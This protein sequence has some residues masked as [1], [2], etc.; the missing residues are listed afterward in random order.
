MGFFK[1]FLA[2]AGA[3]LITGGVA[4]GVCY[5][6]VPEFKDWVQQ[7]LLKIETPVGAVT[8]EKDIQIAD[9]TAQLEQ[10][11][12]TIQAITDE[13]DTQRNKVSQLQAAA[14]QD[15]ETIATLQTSI[16]EK[17]ALLDSATAEKSQLEEQKATL[18]ADLAETQAELEEAQA[19]AETDA[20]TIASLQADV[21]SKQ[22]ELADVNSQLETKTTEV[23][24]LTT[25]VQTLTEERDQ[26]LADLETKES[27]ITTLNEEIASLE[28]DVATKESEIATLNAR[29]ATLEDGLIKDE[30]EMFLADYLSKGF[31]FFDVSEDYAFASNVGF[32]NVKRN[33]YLLNKYDYSLDL[34]CEGYQ[35]YHT[36]FKTDDNRYV[37]SAGNNGVCVVESDLST[38]KTYSLGNKSEQYICKYTMPNGSLVFTNK[39]GTNTSIDFLFEDTSIVVSSENNAFNISCT[40]A[41]QYNKFFVGDNTDSGSLYVVDST[42]GECSEIY[43]GASNFYNFEER[44]QYIKISN[45]SVSIYYNYLTGEVADS[46]QGLEKTVTFY[47][48]D[49]VIGTT[50]LLGG[51]KLD[52]TP[53]KE[54]YTITGWKTLDGTS[55]DTSTPITEDVNLYAIYE[56]LE[57]KY[58]VT[59]KDSSVTIAEAECAEDEFSWAIAPTYT[60][61]EFA[62]WY[63]DGVMYDGTETITLT[64]DMTFY[65][66]YQKKELVESYSFGDYGSSTRTF[67]LDGYTATTGEKLFISANLEFYFG[68]SYNDVIEYYL[69]RG[70]LGT[71]EVPSTMEMYEGSNVSVDLSNFTEGEAYLH[72]DAD[73]PPRAGTINVYK[74]TYL[75]DYMTN[76]IPL[77][78]PDDIV[79]DEGPGSTGGVVIDPGLGGLF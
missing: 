22:S 1:S 55:F 74:V 56:S 15:S 63:C 42:T 48:E 4:A 20:Q 75:Y 8:P 33:L 41:G 47:I 53:T 76:G 72:V 28:S 73:E 12:Q 67:V 34:I 6:K 35:T 45:D 44:G 11:K 37:L 31:N 69:N 21:E 36:M 9:L 59:F 51:T 29:I 50:T 16:T 52:T 19:N 7:D 66:E 39:Y 61:Y 14:K 78:T 70:D 5:S 57:T 68:S 25:Q 71:L 26:A 60:G 62:G 23:E 43:T 40:H 54:G 77:D 79:T 46:V 2:S 27:E 10:H 3:L 64:E 32:I 13:L 18:E 49:Q 17:Q 24:T 30:D 38:S 58:A 65:A